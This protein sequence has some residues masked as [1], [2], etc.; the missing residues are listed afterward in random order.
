[1]NLQKAAVLFQRGAKSSLL[2]NIFFSGFV[3][4][5]NMLTPIVVAPYLTHAIGLEKFGIVNFVWAFTNVMF[6]FIDFGFNLTAVRR[7]SLLR[8]KK[9]G[10]SYLFSRV[11]TLRLLLSF[12]CILVLIGLTFTLEKAIAEQPLFL[13][14]I[15]VLL[16]Y[17]LNS[18]WF[19]QSIEQMKIISLLNVLSKIIFIVSLLVIVTAPQ[20]Y[21]YVLILMGLGN[22]LAGIIGIIIIIHQHKI[23]YQLPSLYSIQNE[24]KEGW[25]ILASNFSISVYVNVAT[26][27]IGLFLNDTILGCYSVV[28]KITLGIRQITGAV[29]NAIYPRICLLVAKKDFSQNVIYRKIYFP[30]LGVLALLLLGVFWLREPIILF[31]V[32]G[33]EVEFTVY[34]LKLMIF[35]PFIT[36]LDGSFYLNLLAHKKIRY[37]SF[38]SIIASVVN[39]ILIYVLIQVFYIEGVIIAI[40][41]T[42]TN[43]TLSFYFLTEIKFKNLS[44]FRSKKTY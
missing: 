37:V 17:A 33:Q 6:V 32:N 30:Y 36:A 29:H 11:I 16:G 21:I 38:I 2:Q 31:F 14:G 15:V 27:F 43:V 12:C 1:M 13:S 44:V 41:I 35:L 34:L 24:L 5:I 22:F 23:H 9:N 25:W 28:E 8:N 39:T 7:G 26:I 3:Q 42:A 18:F 10:L 19:F 4:A 40:Y 20:D